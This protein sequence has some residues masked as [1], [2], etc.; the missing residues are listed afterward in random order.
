MHIHIY[1]LFLTHTHIPVSVG[2]RHYIGSAPS[3]RGVCRGEVL[4]WR[5]MSVGYSG[6]MTGVRCGEKG[7]DMNAGVKQSGHPGWVTVKP[8]TPM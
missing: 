5:F 4:R 8:D 7:K 1:I 3:Q 6:D 2:V